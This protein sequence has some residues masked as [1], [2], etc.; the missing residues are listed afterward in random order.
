M[1]RASAKLKNPATN[2]LLTSPQRGLVEEQLDQLKERLLIPL[3]NSIKN[4]GLIQEL[5]WV[6]NEAAALAWLT[7]CPVLVL[8]TLLEEKARAALQRWERQE[9][10]RL[11]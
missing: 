9:R 10:I 8:P 2:P 7:V 5:R 11:Q 1:K 3:Q 6:A 4:K